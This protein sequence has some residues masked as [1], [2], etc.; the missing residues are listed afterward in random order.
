MTRVLSGAVLIVLAVA[1]V[2]F[3]PSWLFVGVGIF[4]AVLAVNE[5]VALARASRLEVS[6]SAAA[7]ATAVPTI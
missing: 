3:A 4:L 1:V 6:S 7:F 2:W 5:L